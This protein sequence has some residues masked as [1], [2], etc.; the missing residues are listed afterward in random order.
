MASLGWASEPMAAVCWAWRRARP[1]LWA[2]AAVL[3][4]ITTGLTVAT[5]LTVKAMTRDL[6]PETTSS[7]FAAVTCCPFC[8]GVGGGP[9][10]GSALVAASR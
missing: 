7:V 2:A 4:I 6:D 10:P 1:T 9:G 3:Q 8:R 5:T